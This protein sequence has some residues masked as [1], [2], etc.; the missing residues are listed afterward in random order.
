MA[1]STANVKHTTGPSMMV[2]EGNIY[3]LFNP[4][5]AARDPQYVQLYMMDDQEK[6]LA[7]RINR[8]KEKSEPDRSHP[9]RKAEVD[10][11][12]KIVGDLQDM[13][14]TCNPYVKEFKF[15]EEQLRENTND[16][17]LEF[18]V[19]YMETDSKDPKVYNKAPGL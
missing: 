12:N 15:V 18:E 14:H 19:K 9:Q 2:A 7:Q 1:S 13:L 4:L 8:M 3:H 11:F 5:E 16:D 6:E 17:V 10:S